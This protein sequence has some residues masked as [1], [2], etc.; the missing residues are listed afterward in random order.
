MAWSQ[1]NG[2]QAMT[3]GGQSPYPNL[4]FAAHTDWKHVNPALLQSLQ[5]VAKSQGVTVDVISGY[6]SNPYSAANGGFAGDPHT[7]GL[8]VDAYVDGKPIGDVIAPSVWAAAGVR[9][10]NAPG[11]YKGKTDSEHLDLV[12][13]PQT[14]AQTPVA[15]PTPQQPQ[16]VEDPNLQQE[17]MNNIN[18]IPQVGGAPLAS[19]PTTG[20]VDTNLTPTG[21]ASNPNSTWQ[22]I[23]SQGPVS[24]D[25]LRLAQLASSAV[26]AAPSG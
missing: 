21:A 17:L 6:R 16:Q 10:G 3:P 14:P 23:A 24:Q 2:T 11:F 9:S 20:Q 19:V 12:G 22:L 13:E 18:N 25:T 8:A 15:A 4:R 5:R 1:P 7:K 26:N